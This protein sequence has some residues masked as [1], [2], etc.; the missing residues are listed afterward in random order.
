L[1]LEHGVNVCIA[2]R[3]ED[4][5]R[6]IESLLA[7]ETGRHACATRAREHVEKHFGWRAIGM[8]QREML[9]ELLG[10]SITIRKASADDLPAIEPWD[11]GIHDCSVAVVK[12]RVIGFVVTRQTAPGEHELLNIA[13]DAA[14]RRRGIARR[15]LER[16][17]AH[18]PGEWFLEV[19]ESNTP[20]I[21]L[22]ESLGFKPAGRRDNY[23]YNPVDTAIVMR[24][25]S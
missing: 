17:L 7:D 19:R 8:R 10:D 12:N 2:D 22:Y 16:E 15:L 1:G 4:F 18:S 20:A 23:Y 24:F 25:F 13:V 5:A 3:P 9:R 14:E 6:G 11:P 21:R